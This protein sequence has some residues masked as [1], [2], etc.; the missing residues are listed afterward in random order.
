[1]EITT[2]NDSAPID[3]L[4]WLNKATLDIIGL[5][6]MRYDLNIVPICYIYIYNTGFNYKFNALEEKYNELYEAVQTVSS[7]P[8]NLF[9]LITTHIPFLGI[10]VCIQGIPSIHFT[11]R[12]SDSQP[13]DGDDTLKLKTPYVA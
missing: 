2:A 7:G 4:L 1:M 12:M 6:G 3:I 13:P 10:I 5:A 8:L 9:D 11:Y